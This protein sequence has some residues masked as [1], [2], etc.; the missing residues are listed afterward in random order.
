MPPSGRSI[1]VNTL[2]EERQYSR[3]IQKGGNVNVEKYRNEEHRGSGCHRPF[4]CSQCDSSTNQEA[5]LPLGS[6][7]EFV[8]FPMGG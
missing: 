3:S 5:G 1:D 4:C 2:V 6:T 7:P 8:Y